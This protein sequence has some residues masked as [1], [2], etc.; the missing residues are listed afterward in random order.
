MNIAA[1][2]LVLLCGPPVDDPDTEYLVRAESIGYEN[3]VVP[4]NGG[5]PKEASLRTIETVC[6]LDQPFL[7]RAIV[8]PATTSIRGVLR[9]ADDGEHDFTI[10]LECS[11][12]VNSGTSVAVAP[13]VRE[14]VPDVTSARSTVSLR[15][16]SPFEIGGVTTRS[17]D[18]TADSPKPRTAMSKLV[19]R[20]TVEKYRPDSQ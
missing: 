15:E 16:G 13:G 17:T 11:H 3:A 9:K 6:R 10:D 8:G 1:L 7:A 12:V 19:V 5:E 4:E 14:Q 20:I 18:K 2:S